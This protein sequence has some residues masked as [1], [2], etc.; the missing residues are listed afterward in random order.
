M[1]VLFGTA[2]LKNR[3]IDFVKKSKQQYRTK[4]H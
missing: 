2:L 3:K 1:T 4:S